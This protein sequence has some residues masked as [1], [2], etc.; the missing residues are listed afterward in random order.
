[1]V[2]I[3]RFVGQAEGRSTKDIVARVEEQVKAS[4]TNNLTLIEQDD[5]TA[6]FAVNFPAREGQTAKQQLVRLWKG[7]R[8]MHRLAY[9]HQGDLPSEKE[10]EKWYRIVKGA[11]LRPYN[12][13][14]SKTSLTFSPQNQVKAIASA[15][16]LDLR[17]AAEYKPTE[18]SLIAIAA[19][20][21]SA[22]KLQAY[23][24]AVY[25]ELDQ[26][27]A[28]GKPNQTEILVFGPAAEELPGGYNDARQHFKAGVKFYGFKYVAPGEKLGMSFDGVFEVD[29]KW[30]FLPKAHRA[31]R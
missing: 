22:K 13:N 18:K 2:T 6:I 8:D 24:D 20:D 3:E 1:M 7:T 4:G 31:F 19:N 11:D 16:R 27:G 21:E 28:A 10:R 14:V 17:K 30:Y 25:K 12:P 15:L 29:G 23:C 9:T 5:A 26:A